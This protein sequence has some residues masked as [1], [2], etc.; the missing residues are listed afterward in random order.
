MLF[1]CLV[2][3]LW[4]DLFVCL[5]GLLCTMLCCFYFWFVMISVCL[6]FRLYVLGCSV[7][8]LRGVWCTVVWIFVGFIGLGFIWGF[9]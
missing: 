9:I 6:L 7:F 3:C 1:A 5:F 4:F 2:S 8:S